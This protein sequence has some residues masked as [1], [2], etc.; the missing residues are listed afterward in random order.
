MLFVEE[1][2]SM[3]YQFSLDGFMV[4]IDSWKFTVC[5]QGTDEALLQHGFAYIAF[6]DILSWT[7]ASIKAIVEVSFQ[8]FIQALLYL[9][10]RE[11]VV[12]RPDIKL[13]YEAFCLK[14]TQGSLQKS[15]H[16]W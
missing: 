15:L 12:L 10:V 9:L 14:D 11:F 13:P 1:C 3:P 16:N 4:V 5:F 8:S 2:N 7:E 6:D